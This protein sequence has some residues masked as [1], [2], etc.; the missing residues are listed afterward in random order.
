MTPID[1]NCTDPI[2]Y[3][4]RIIEDHPKG[5]KPVILPMAIYSNARTIK[6]IPVNPE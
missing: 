4:L 2:K 3:M 1:S 5:A 6:M